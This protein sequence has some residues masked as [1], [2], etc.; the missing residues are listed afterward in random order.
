MSNL[1]TPKFE[2]ALGF[3]FQLHKNQY[4]KQSQIPYIS[5]LL[6]VTAI[7]LE[8]GG[9]ENQ[10][11]AAL[12]HDAVEDQGGYDTLQ[13]IEEMF[14]SEVAEIVEGCTDA[15]TDP[16]PEWKGRKTAYL[17]KLKEFPDSILLV[18]LADKVHNA[19]SILRDLQSKE[20]DI[21]KRFNGGKEG[22]LWYYQSLVEI[23][24][25]SPYTELTSELNRVVK[26]IVK[27]SE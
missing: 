14:G 27:L 10:A 8:N 12:L 26:E 21:W 9:S 24:N 22:T 20:K 7:V 19:L 15:F 16:K 13:K 17:K 1:L 2:T 3:A 11:I 5:H 18:S 23:F 6:A 4:R 25:T